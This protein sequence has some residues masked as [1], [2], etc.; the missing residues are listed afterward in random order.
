MLREYI[1][2]R[3]NHPDRLKNKNISFANLIDFSS[4]LEENNK[5]QWAWK[6]LRLAN[7]IRNQLA[8]SLLPEKL[9]KL[10]SEFIEYVIAN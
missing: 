2:E 1:Y 8:H 10:E 7:Q 5:I 6:A 4:S 9:E 3:V